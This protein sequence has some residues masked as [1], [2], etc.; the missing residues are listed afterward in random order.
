L[1]D[2]R[3]TFLEVKQVGSILGLEIRDGFQLEEGVNFLQK[4]FLP[5]KLSETIRRALDS[6]DTPQA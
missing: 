1:N 3:A 2:L 4:P 5:Q 6:E